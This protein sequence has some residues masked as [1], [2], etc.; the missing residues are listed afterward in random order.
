[1]LMRLPHP[2]HPIP[3]TPFRLPM[4]REDFALAKSLSSDYHLVI[5]DLPECVLDAR[6]TPEYRRAFDRFL[7]NAIFAAFGLDACIIVSYRMGIYSASR[8]RPIKVILSSRHAVSNLLASVQHFSKVSL[9]WFARFARF[10]RSDHTKVKANPYISTHLSLN[11]QTNR[12]DTKTVI[13]AETQTDHFDQTPSSSQISTM[14]SNKRGRPKKSSATSN[15][16]RKVASRKGSTGV[17]HTQ[18]IADTAISSAF[19]SPLSKTT[20]PASKIIRTSSQPQPLRPPP[21]GSTTI[22]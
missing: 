17:I 13:E 4:T 22:K 16:K 10:R 20:S 19:S 18:P 12:M 8:P 15:I 1:M 3:P 21:T 11:S 6:I 14:P 7:I 2:H 9:P 5:E